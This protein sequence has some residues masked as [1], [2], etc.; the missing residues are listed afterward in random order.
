VDEA[1]A[2][3]DIY[4]AYGVAK[5]PDLLDRDAAIEAIDSFW[6]IVEEPDRV[7]LIIAPEFEKE[8]KSHLD[9]ELAAAFTQDRGAYGR[10][11]GKAIPKADG[12]QV[13]IVDIQMF[14]KGAPSPEPTLRHE[15]L[16]VLLHQRS[17]SSNQSR[18]TSEDHEGLHPDMVA[19]AGIAAEEYR[20]ERAVDRPQE[21]IWSS[22][23]ALCAAG[24]DAIHTAAV[25]YYYDH[26]VEAI[27]R[28]V[29]GAFSPMTVQSAYLAVWVDAAGVPVPSLA[30]TE[31]SERMLG[32]GWSEVVA[33]F[34]RLP[35]ADTP[36]PHSEL[37]T[38]V[39][40]IA[41][42][43]DDWLAD[44]GFACEQVGDGLRFDV[45]EHEDWVMRGPVAAKVADRD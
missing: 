19:L 34:C 18:E 21:G 30:D 2:E 35:P 7:T 26:D 8:V 24:H 45:Y 11:M 29:I 6:D 31:L 17:E 25:A 20:V 22:F 41:H 27:W 1:E 32:E 28:A 23:E 14:L 5:W 9:A 16:H 38:A 13:V 3:I 43:F 42:R 37:A 33:A 10:A 39:I 12:T 4:E 36:V 15:A 44:I 40:E